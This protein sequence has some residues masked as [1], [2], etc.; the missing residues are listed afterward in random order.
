MQYT[1]GQA[2][3]QLPPVTTNPASQR[4]VDAAEEHLEGLTQSL[5]KQLENARGRVRRWLLVN[6]GYI[7]DD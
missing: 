1:D 7:T 2:D 4:V 5:D 6:D 3:A